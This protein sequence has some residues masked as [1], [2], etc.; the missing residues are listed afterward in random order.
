MME[1][2]EQIDDEEVVAEVPSEPTWPGA[3]E[4]WFSSSPTIDIN[5]VNTPQ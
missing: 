5:G 4:V 1:Q 2:W 3:Q